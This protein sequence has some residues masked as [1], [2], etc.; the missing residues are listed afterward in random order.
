MTELKTHCTRHNA[1][2]VWDPRSLVWKVVVIGLRR[3]SPIHGHPHWARAKFLLF[4]LNHGVRSQPSSFLRKS[5]FCVL[6]SP[7]KQAY[8]AYKSRL[9]TR[10]EIY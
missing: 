4:E 5:M 3:V 8:M 9:N 10:A 7:N 6:W 2:V 1:T